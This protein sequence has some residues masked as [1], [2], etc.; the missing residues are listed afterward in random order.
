MF[1]RTK[2]DSQ[3]KE[4]MPIAATFVSTEDSPHLKILIKPVEEKADVTGRR[5]VR[6]DASGMRVS[7]RAGTYR[8]KSQAIL[9]G[10][11]SHKAFGVSSRGF[12]IDDRDETGFWRATGHIEP[13]TVLVAKTKGS[14]KSVKGAD[15][16][17]LVNMV[18]ANLAE[19]TEKDGTIIEVVPLA[20]L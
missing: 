20:H 2:I 3:Y 1:K 5:S 12:S 9:A 6:V 18:K 16:K 7:F 8:T 4:D 13:V 11:L 15:V 14:P 19:R 10:L 17:N